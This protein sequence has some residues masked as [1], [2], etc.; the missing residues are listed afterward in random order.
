MQYP[1]TEKIGDPDLLVGR[2][3]EFRNFNNWIADI[4]R[5][6]SKSTAIM[7]RR[8][9]GKTAIVQRLF[10]QLWS[11][12]GAVIPFYFEFAE[13]KTW[14]PDLAIQYYC[15]F[16]SHYISFLERN[17][18]WVDKRLSLEQIREYGLSQSI[19]EFVEDVDF[20]VKN[21]AVGGSHDLMWELASTAPHYFASRYNKRF[22]VILDE[23]QYI[24]RYIYR[25]EKGEGNP[26]ETLAGSYH[27]LS[28]SKIAPLLITGSY[29]SW[30]MD[31][32]TKY[33]Q[34]GRLTE[35]YI[36]PYL[37]PDEGLQAVYQYAE[38]Y[39]ASMTNESALLLN[40]LCMADPFFISCVI[41]HHTNPN[42]ETKEEV[43]N[44]VHYQISNR[45]SEMS[46][47]WYEYLI[48]TLK[49]VNDKQAKNLLLFLSKHSEREWTPAE[50]KKELQLPLTVNEV[51]EKLMLLFGAD[52]IAEG[53]T[54][55]DYK[56][57]SDGTLNLIIRHRFEKEIKGFIP[58]IKQEFLD[59]V[60]ALTLDNKRLRGQL[61]SLSGKMA[62]HQ[63]AMAFRS[64]KRFA[65]S[66]FFQ[67]VVDT[68]VLNLISVK[69]RVLIQRED[70][71]NM[72]IDIVAESSCGRV[73][74]VEVK[75]TQAKT[76]LKMVEYFQ[77]K[78][79]VYQESHP[80]KQVLPA[81][82]SL[83]GFTEQEALPFCQAQGI[84]TAV[85]I[86]QY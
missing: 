47:T 61:S 14:Y 4:P 12:N 43:V 15:T 37:T 69:E 59:Q 60:G 67:N 44:A 79:T 22:L 11:E 52:L 1:L 18:K 7:A 77:E 81:F 86:E 38:F 42:L 13:K 45:R 70:G 51:Q 16:A 32:M 35:L 25:D 82:L 56:G 21:K 85:R 78:I 63:L 75:K 39:Q 76:G 19:E 57:L 31:I 66:A 27:S 36:S 2:E 33:L 9:S 80:D 10:N 17:K 55:I 26:D 49:R 74:L 48:Y 34:G 71:K 8:K 54:D 46:R 24:T 29:M 72:E 84:A 41:R 6:G 62:E 20:L 53:P 64:R 30:L 3:N 83:G 73:V 65:L 68:T 50:L 5:K 40:E 23:F 28:E 58:D